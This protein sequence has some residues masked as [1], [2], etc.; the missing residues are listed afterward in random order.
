MDGLKRKATISTWYDGDD[1]NN[2]K[3]GF[4]I[5]LYRGDSWKKCDL[6]EK[7]GSKNKAGVV[8]RIN[9]LIKFVDDGDCDNLHGYIIDESDLTN[10]NSIDDVGTFLVK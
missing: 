7:F 4:Y 5:C 2:S 6:L 9:T 8:E 3:R 1:L 10:Q